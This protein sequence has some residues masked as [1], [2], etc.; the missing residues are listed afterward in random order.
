MVTLLEVLRLDILCC[1]TRWCVTEPAIYTLITDKIRASRSLT[2]PTPL[3]VPCSLFPV[4]CSLFP[5][6]DSRFPTPYSL[7][8]APCS[9]FPVPF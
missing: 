3:P 7:L 4:P 1:L 2:H 8:P 6:P 9:L 5:V